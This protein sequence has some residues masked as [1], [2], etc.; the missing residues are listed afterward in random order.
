[1]EVNGVNDA[2]LTYV[3]LSKSIIWNKERMDETN[4]NGYCIMAIKNEAKNPR[5][6]DSNL[7]VH[8]PYIAH[9]NYIHGYPCINIC[10]YI[11][12]YMY[13]YESGSIFLS[14]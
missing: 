2:K 6:F 14:N 4:Y 13:A 5:S 7:D 10:T 12:I 1:M 11:Y 9:I 8:Y 3:N